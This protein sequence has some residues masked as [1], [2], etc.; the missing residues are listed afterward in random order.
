MPTLEHALCPKHSMQQQKIH[1][2]ED[3]F[4]DKV[5]AAVFRIQGREKS[6]ATI[7]REGEQPQNLGK[8][9]KISIEPS[10]HL[11]VS[12][13][14]VRHKDSLLDE[15][16]R[17]YESLKSELNAKELLCFQYKADYDKL[18]QLTDGSEERTSMITSVHSTPHSLEIW[19]HRVSQKEE[20]LENLKKDDPYAC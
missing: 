11:V 9:E 20:E 2:V 3:R 8:P 18:L 14:R 19:Q 5:S 15:K 4:L 6:K 10:R 13:Q 17:D 7:Q 1:E 16:Q 12:Q